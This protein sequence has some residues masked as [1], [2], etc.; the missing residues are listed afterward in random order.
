[1]SCGCEKIAK[2]LSFFAA[3]TIF[4]KE[5]VLYNYGRLLYLAAD[6]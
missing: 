3:D 4:W 2:F 6:N 5:Q 1:M